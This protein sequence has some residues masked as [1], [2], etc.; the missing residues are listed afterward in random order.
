MTATPTRPTALIVDDCPGVIEVIT[1]VLESENIAVIPAVSVASARRILDATLPELLVTDLNLPD[2]DGLDVIESCR[3]HCTHIAIVVLTGFPD[4][5]RIRD[6]MDLGIS[7]FLVKPFTPQQLK[8][9]VIRAM[10][11][12]KV[13]LAEDLVDTAGNTGEHAFGL[14]GSSAYITRLRK[15]ISIM[16]DGDF[17]VLI[18]GPSGT[19]K[20]IIAKSIHRN[21]NRSAEQMVTINCAAIPHHLEESEFFGYAKGAFTDARTAKH[22]IL[23]CADRSTLF[24]DEL[25]ELSLAVQ[26]KLLRVL[27]TGE[28]I[29]IGEVH[30]RKVDIRILS[31]TNRNLREMVASGCFRVDLYFRLKGAMI[32][33]EPLS[34]HTEDIPEL[35]RYFIAEFDA[36]KQ[37][38]REA[39]ERLSRYEWQGNIRELKNTLQYIV[40]RSK[41]HRRITAEMVDG[42]LGVPKDTDSASQPFA[43]V[44]EQF[45]RDYF[46][47][48]LRLHGGNISRV[49]REAAIHR[50]N[51]LHK[52]KELGIDPGTYRNSENTTFT[53][54]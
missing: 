11:E 23:E 28:F 4:E 50:P 20:E 18:H 5:Q 41:N 13:C 35:S 14:I 19:G 49:A 44:K 29:R 31:A 54:I 2:G 12:R 21:S 34:T 36:A 32:T 10:E 38:T 27:D 40:A 24:L 53:T 43:K 15:S 1:D 16:A 30:P 39:S 47:S 52:L 42:V 8:Y 25:G 37:L 45:E 51:L 48:L 26:A 7:T 22:G 9:A 6:M 17:P 46:V 33:T 3:S